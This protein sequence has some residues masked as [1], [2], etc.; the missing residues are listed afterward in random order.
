MIAER[1]GATPPSTSELKSPPAEPSEAPSRV[2][3]VAWA[4]AMLALVLIKISP[5]TF[6]D[7]DVWHQLSLAREIWRSGHVPT[8]DVFAYTPTLRPLVH[9]EW[10]AGVLWLAIASAGGKAGFLLFKYLL[11]AGVLALSARAARRRGADAV[12]LLACALPAILLVHYGFTTIRAQ[13]VSLLALALLL[14]VLTAEAAGRRRWLIGWLFLHVL[15]LNVHAGFVVGVGFLGL[16]TLERALRREP[17]VHLALCTAAASALVLLNPWG[18]AYVEYL[19]R[20]L[21]TEERPDMPEWAPLWADLRL[22]WAD[23]ATW[24][25]MVGLTG[26]A[27]R[28]RGLR[29]CR[30]ITLVAASAVFALL[31]Q[32]HVTFLA[33]TWFVVAVPWLA[34]TPLAERLRRVVASRGR[35]VVVL[36]GLAFAVWFTGGMLL[37]PWALRIPADALAR[38]EAWPTYPIGAA[39]YLEAEDFRGNLM[40]P[41]VEGAYMM[42]RIRPRGGRVSYD[43][44]YAAAYPPSVT[45]DHRTFYSAAAGWESVLR[46]YPTDVVLVPRP[47]PVLGAMLSLPDWHIVYGDDLYV[48]IARAGL[49]M[50]FV[51]HRGRAFQASFP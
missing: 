2:L 15:W 33:I 48:L 36:S 19:A 32:R 10:G 18:P 1:P 43:G 25:S 27:V 29:A 30:G 7:P 24:A 35:L 26:Y 13:L 20:W 22:R 21:L 45:A 41:F 46:A 37:R 38:A 12:T 39:D 28:V 31:H 4:M 50:P 14:N 23:L 9:H 40:T 17:F 42:W 47:S 6:V 16:A 49:E 3:L 44:R 5:L 8:V 34:D 11:V 51:D